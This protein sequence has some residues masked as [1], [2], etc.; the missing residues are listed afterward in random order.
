MAHPASN[1]SAIHVLLAE[2]YPANVLVATTLLEL[3]GFT[4]DVANNGQE[5]L[6][7]LRSGTPYDVVLMDV[8][9]PDL[10]G[11]EATRQW[12]ESEASSKRVPIIGMT[13][14]A[15]PDN[16]KKCFDMGMDAYIGKPFHAEELE[17]KILS[18]ANRAMAA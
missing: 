9:M 2:D 16:I 15:M 1:P 5:A 12:R 3:M 11:Y 4:F 13:A 17:E 7:K 18:F 6:D 10:D 14:H 8:E